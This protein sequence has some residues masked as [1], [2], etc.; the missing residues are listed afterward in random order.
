MTGPGI[1]STTGDIGLF[2]QWAVWRQDGLWIH[3]T[4]PYCTSRWII[5]Q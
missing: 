2:H 3:L 5:L 4:S 1:G